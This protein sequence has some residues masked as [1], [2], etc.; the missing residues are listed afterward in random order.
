MI[1]HNKQIL[2]ERGHGD[3]MAEF[4]PLLYL[5]FIA[6]QSITFNVID[7]FDKSPINNYYDNPVENDADLRRDVFRDTTDPN[8]KY[9]SDLYFYTLRQT[10]DNIN[11]SIKLH[12]A[13]I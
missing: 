3:Q 1:Y 12:P 5:Y 2:H 7:R 6:I 11:R 13:T 10:I 9:W 8:T 4:G